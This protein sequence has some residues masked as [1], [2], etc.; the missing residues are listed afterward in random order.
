MKGMTSGTVAKPSAKYRPKKV[1]L[2]RHTDERSVE[3]PWCARMNQT[4]WVPAKPTKNR[5][6]KRYGRPTRATHGCGGHA[7]SGWCRRHVLLLLRSRSVAIKS[8]AK[9]RWSKKVRM[10]SEGVARNVRA[11]ADRSLANAR[12]G[13]TPSRSSETTGAPVGR[14]STVERNDKLQHR[15]S[16]RMH[17]VFQRVVALAQPG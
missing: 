11:L 16:G 6:T 5:A 7:L 14:G 10:T 8:P 2:S 9:A 12:Q 17:H 13:P 1:Q 15:W 3:W 4:R